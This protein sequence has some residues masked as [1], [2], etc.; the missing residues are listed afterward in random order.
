D[1]VDPKTNQQDLWLYDASGTNARR[2]TYD[3]AN[4]GVPVWAPDGSRIVWASNRDGGVLNLYQKAASGAG[5]E[6]LLW[7]SD[8]AKLPTDLSRDGRYILYTQFDKKGDVWALPMGGSGEAK[9]FPVVHTEAREQEGTLSPD[10]RWLAYTSD[11]SGRKEVYVQSFPG[12]G[13]KRQVSTGGGF[14]PHW[15]R[16]GR[17]LFFYAGAGKLM[18][19]P[20]R[21]GGGLGRGG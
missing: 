10:G 4:D 17:G 7:T 18:G 12:G 2:F 3:L 8:Y 20:V 5:E 14:S 21:S 1:L 9:P 19:A 15:R 6:T 16:D 11:V 13:G